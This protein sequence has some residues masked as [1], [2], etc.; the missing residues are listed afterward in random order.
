MS[1]YLV[2]GGAGFIGSALVRS[3]VAS[4]EHE[5]VNVDLLTYA[6][7]LESLAMARDNPRHSFHRLDVADAAVVAMVLEETQPDV[8][9]HLAAETH[10]D[11][12]IDG[13][14]RFMETNITGTFVMLERSLDYWRRLSPVRRSA[15]RFV[16]VSTDEV[17]GS[18]G[19][20]GRFT[21]ETRYNPSSPYSASKAG[22]DHLVRA[23]GRTYGL[24][25]IVTNCSN[26]YGPY[27]F[28]EKLIP[29]VIN[30]AVRGDAIPVYGSGQNVRDW[31]HVDDHVRALRLVADGGRSQATYLIGGGEECTNLAV[32]E[33]ICAVLDELDPRG[34]PHS[35]LIT[36][37][38]DRPGHDFRYAIDYSLI[39]REL[40]WEPL[41]GLTSG[42]RETVEWYLRNEA[43]T[44]Q[45]TSGA[46]RGERL[47]AGVAA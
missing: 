28:P 27:Q 30:K 11:R 3:L 26:N 31:L 20:E 7:S 9:V 8:V 43:W 13:P 38:E 47:G 12:S 4:G 41:V 19:H 17:F 5:V 45:V 22:A 34:L 37:V 35:K 2:T 10:V 14:A 29:L 40:G 33:K 32:V 42:I 24:P 36:F 1:K 39:R 46:W 21:P 25:V 6:G 18:L 23:W 16:H 15:F 44:M